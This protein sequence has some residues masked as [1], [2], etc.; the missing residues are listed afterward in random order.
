MHESLPGSAGAIPTAVCSPQGPWGVEALNRRIHP[1]LS[2]QGR[3]VNG[4]EW[5][6]GRPYPV[7]DRSS[8]F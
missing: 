7:L 6:D 4:R 8:P 3:V 5:F 2:A 1:L